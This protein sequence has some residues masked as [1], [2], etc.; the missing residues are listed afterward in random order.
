M[1]AVRG[2]AL[3][4]RFDDPARGCDRNAPVG[5]CGEIFRAGQGMNSQ[6]IASAVIGAVGLAAGTT[7]AVLAHRRR[8]VTAPNVGPGFAGVVVQG[9]F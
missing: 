2:K 5:E 7:L 9:R 3:R 1:G 6:L 4:Q 8:I